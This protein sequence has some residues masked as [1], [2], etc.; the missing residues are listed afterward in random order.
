[1]A[2]IDPIDGRIFLILSATGHA[3]ILPLLYPDNLVVLKLLLLLAHII[4]AD[5]LLCKLFKCSLLKV[6]EYFYILLLPIIAIYHAFIHKI[7]FD[8]KMEFLPLALTSMYS[9]VGITYCWI[10]Y[11]YYFYTNNYQLPKNSIKNK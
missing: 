9:A 3:S 4:L 11:F 1:M 6:Y 8:G 5:Y 10:L 7:I 2:T